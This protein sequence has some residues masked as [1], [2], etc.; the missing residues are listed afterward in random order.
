MT[1]ALLFCG[2]LIKIFQRLFSAST[3]KAPV[4][5]NIFM[6]S[7]Q[8]HLRRYA[9]KRVWVSSD[10]APSVSIQSRW[11]TKF[12]RAALQ[13]SIARATLRHRADIGR[14]ALATSIFTEAMFAAMSSGSSSSVQ[15]GWLLQRGSAP[16]S[17]KIAALATARCSPRFSP[18]R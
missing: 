7:S 2:L 17:T 15:A 18:S 1:S 16:P 4:L 5:R 11:G 13:R 6:C 10:I 3:H 14:A 8:C 12:F 9:P